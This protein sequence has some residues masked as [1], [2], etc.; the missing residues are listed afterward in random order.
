MFTERTIQIYEDLADHFGRQKD[1]RQRDIFL[2]LAADAAYALG[3]PD[4]AERLRLRLLQGSP[5]SLLKPYSSFG[6]ARK[7]SDIQLFLEDLRSQYPPEAAEKLIVAK[8]GTVPPKDAEPKGYRLLSEP[9]KPKPVASPWSRSAETKAKD[10]KPPS[11][12]PMVEDDKDEEEELTPGSWISLLL[13]VLVLA[14]VL[15]LAVYPFLQKM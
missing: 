3:H 14:G 15:A 9:E 6:E 4:H 11:S 1:A 7:S 10:K 2:V 8:G 13:F 5:H 12:E